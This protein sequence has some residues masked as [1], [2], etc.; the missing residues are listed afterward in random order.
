[1]TPRAPARPPHRGAAGRRAA[2]RAARA[3]HHAR[4]PT[5]PT[6]HA[7]PRHGE[8]APPREQAL[9]VHD[10]ERH[11][12]PVR[13]A[14]ARPGKR[15][16]ERT[17]VALRGDEPGGRHGRHEPHGLARRAA[18]AARA[19]RSNSMTNAMPVRLQHRR[20]ARVRV[21]DH[22]GVRDLA[23]EQPHRAEHGEAD[24]RAPVTQHRRELGAAAHGQHQ[25]EQHARAQHA[26]RREQRGRHAVAGQAGTAR[27]R[28]R[29]PRARRR[30]SAHAT[31]RRWRRNG[32][33]PQARF[34]GGALSS[35]RRTLSLLPVRAASASG[36]PRCAVAGSFPAVLLLRRA[37]PVRPAPAR[38]A[39]ANSSRKRAMGP[40]RLSSS[41][42]L[43]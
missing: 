23:Q 15:Q 22:D 36:L 19:R 11:R 39:H 37:G 20:R 13:D 4:R 12:Q 38:L 30:T 16:D 29:S 35:R 32:K 26:H 10:V 7:Q 41:S 2:R 34:S 1:M 9:R 8:A 17:R 18:A 33:A 3:P 31:P 24:H 43:K 28:P 27:T 25:Q 14:P 21:P 42:S 5:P 6:K 40:S